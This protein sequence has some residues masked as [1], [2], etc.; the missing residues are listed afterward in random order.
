[1]RI[2]LAIA[3]AALALTACRVDPELPP[4]GKTSAY[5]PTPVDPA[6]IFPEKFGMPA[7]PADNPFTEEGIYLGRMLFYDPILSIDSSISC[8]SCHFQQ[9]A[10]GDPRTFSTGVFGLKRGAMLPHCSTWPTAA[11]SFGMLVRTPFGS[12]C[13]SL[14][15]HTTRWP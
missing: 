14:F 3:T 1:M 8:A 12:K 4:G 6:E 7:L 9:N 15:K 5:Q 2:F 13:L 10:F 11:S